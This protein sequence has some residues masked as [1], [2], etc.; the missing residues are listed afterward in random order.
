[1]ARQGTVCKGT[2]RRSDLDGPK[3]AALE[4][5]GRALGMTGRTVREI[6]RL[7]G[8]SPDRLTG[9]KWFVRRFDPDD[10]RR[11]YWFLVEL[12]DLLGYSHELQEVLIHILSPDPLPVEPGGTLDRICTEADRAK[13]SPESL[14][15]LA[16]CLMPTLPDSPD[17]P[18]S[19]LL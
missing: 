3:A 16:F 18:I 8:L 7:P 9:D 17:D 4:E 1:M 11:N 15:H 13:L 5:V 12:V 2:G 6:M 10:P 14:R 19:R